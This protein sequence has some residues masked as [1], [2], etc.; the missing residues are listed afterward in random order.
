MQLM[1]QHKYGLRVKN[2]QVFINLIKQL[3]V[4]AVTVDFLEIKH[5][6]PVKLNLMGCSTSKGNN[7][8]CNNFF[9]L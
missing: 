6:S 3:G 5:S 8:I 9:L 7:K 2:E 4:A 1:A